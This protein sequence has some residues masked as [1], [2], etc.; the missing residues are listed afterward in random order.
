MSRTAYQ[1]EEHGL[2]PS[3]SAYAP[4]AKPRTLDMR[5]TGHPLDPHHVGTFIK[6]SELV[7]AV[8]ISSLNRSELVLYNQLLAHA[9]NAIEPGKV[10]RIRKADLRTSH[11]SNDLLHEAFHRLMSGFAR[12]KYRDPVS[13]KAMT[14]RIHL[15]GPNTEEDADSGYFYYTFHDTLL[16]ILEKSQTWARL[17]ACATRNIGFSRQ[18]P[19]QAAAIGG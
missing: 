1:S 10:Y 3:P 5:V 2:T 17:K 7:G 15:L 12:V 16:K 14:M 13:G 19:R 4:P 9:W 6:P 8:E 18:T 11:G